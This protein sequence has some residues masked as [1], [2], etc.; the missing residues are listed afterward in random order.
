[1]H[2][3]THSERR[4]KSSPRKLV[5]HCRE[6]IETSHF[7]TMEYKQLK[8]A[9]FVVWIILSGIILFTLSTPFIF[10]ENSIDKI[11]PKC[12]WRVAYNKECYL[13]GM[14]RSFICFSQGNFTRARELNRFSPYLCLLFVTNQ[15]A[16]M[17]VL[18][19]KF[20]KVSFKNNFIPF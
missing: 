1:M 3:A 4:R 13:C 19:W 2:L 17:F 11:V 8:L 12:E 9:I 7:L 14:T 6:K 16:L 18:F 10:S 5:I 15:A 20:K